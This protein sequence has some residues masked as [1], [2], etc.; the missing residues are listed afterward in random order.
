MLLGKT[1]AVIPMGMSCQTAHQVEH[2]KA[3][4]EI[5]VGEELEK[6]RTPFEWRIVGPADVA[7]MIRENNPYPA[8][9]DELSGDGNR[10]WA[11]RRCWFWHDKWD[12]FARFSEKQAHLWSNWGRIREASRKIFVLCDTQNN[13]ARVL[14]PLGSKPPTV[15][16]ASLCILWRVLADRFEGAELH[17]VTDDDDHRGGNLIYADRSLAPVRVHWIAPDRSSWQ[18]DST[19]WGRILDRIVAPSETKPEAAK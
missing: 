13:L 1:T 4:L 19:A 10:Y 16:A 17:F 9:A 2:R 12:D 18:G 7:G 6:I 3:K 8:S 5:I 14:K 11:R 15:G